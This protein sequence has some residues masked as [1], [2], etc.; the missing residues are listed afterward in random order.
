MG[1]SD[2]LFARIIAGLDI[3]STFGYNKQSKYLHRINY[4]SFLCFSDQNVML[5]RNCSV[6][7]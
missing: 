4:D 2:E 7:S 1:D 6:S 5:H 3:P